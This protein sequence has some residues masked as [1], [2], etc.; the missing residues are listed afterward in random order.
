MS[1]LMTS[2]LTTTIDTHLAAYGEP[3]AA[4]RAQLVRQVWSSTG[5]L[6]D[7][8]QHPALVTGDA[9]A[10]DVD[11]L[12]AGLPATIRLIGDSK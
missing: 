6:L 8:N 11:Y 7:P 5:Q 4:T 3:D 10:N 2:D 12:G 9:A 1:E